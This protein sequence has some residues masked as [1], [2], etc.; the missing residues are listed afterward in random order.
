VTD[1]VDLIMDDHARIRRLFA[2][3]D[4]AARYRE[5]TADI[6]KHTP[7]QRMLNEA[8]ARLARSLELHTEAEEEICYPHVPAAREPTPALAECCADHRDIREALADARLREPGSRAWWRAVAAA[9][10]ACGRHFPAEEQNVLA[11]FHRC[12]PPELRKDLARRWRTFILARLRDLP[13]G[14]APRPAWK[15]TAS[16]AFPGRLPGDQDR[17]GLPHSATSRSG[18]GAGR[19]NSSL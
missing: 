19:R 14:E 5:S 16:Y 6:G 7:G 18:T 12:S 3:L 8:W 11:P 2:A 10:T 17:S 13:A 15:Q 4:S 9:R 1:I